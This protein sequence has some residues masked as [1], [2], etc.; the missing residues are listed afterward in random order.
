[1]S[2]GS[3]CLSNFGLLFL[4]L[5]H[6]SIKHDCLL[7]VDFMA[8]FYGFSIF[9]LE[10]VELEAKD[11]WRQ[12]KVFSLNSLYLHLCATVSGCIII[13]VKVI[14]CTIYLVFPG[15]VKVLET[16]YLYHDGSKGLGNFLSHIFLAIWSLVRNKVLN[17]ALE[18]L[19][20]NIISQHFIYLRLQ[21]FWVVQLPV[22]ILR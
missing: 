15:R 10:S 20:D 2:Q 16:N 18:I 11:F 21:I 1:M 22:S 7:N 9:V 5:E 3:H 8:V 14:Y 19:C 4:V 13:H 17:T 6:E 12:L